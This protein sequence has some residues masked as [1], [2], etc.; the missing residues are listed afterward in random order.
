MW[1][2]EKWWNHIRG[3]FLWKG[4]LKLRINEYLKLKEKY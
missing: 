4:S 3:D 2:Q 1:I